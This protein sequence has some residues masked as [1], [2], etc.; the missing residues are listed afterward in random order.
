M[1][2]NGDNDGNAFH[3]KIGR[4]KLK[5]IIFKCINAW[6]G[7]GKCNMWMDTM[8]DNLEAL[9]EARPWRQYVVDVTTGK[10]VAK[11]GL[12]PFNMDGKCAVIKKACAKG[13]K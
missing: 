3:D 13:G 4:T 8:D 2:D 7:D 1:I 11:I 6:M 12:A 9:Y 10:V 5:S